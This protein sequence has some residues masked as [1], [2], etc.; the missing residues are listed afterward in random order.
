MRKVIGITILAALFGALFLLVASA[1]GGFM[2]AAIIMGSSLAIAALIVY[3][4]K[5]IVD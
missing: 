3:S 2:N 5:L 4:V 1:K